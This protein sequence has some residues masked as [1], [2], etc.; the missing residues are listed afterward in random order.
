[1][2]MTGDNGREIQSWR[3]DQLTPHPMQKRLYGEPPAAEVED[4]ADDLRRNGQLQPLEILRDGSSG[5]GTI[6]AGHKRTAAAKLLGWETL[7]VWV[8]DDLAH[9]P[10]AVERRLI[11]DNLNRRQLG[12]LA[13]ARLYK[14]LRELERGGGDGRLPGEQGQDL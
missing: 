3:V 6:I 2:I 14:R 5:A 12:R 8:R 1:M 9:D 11:E 13:K 10:A 7:L 4:L